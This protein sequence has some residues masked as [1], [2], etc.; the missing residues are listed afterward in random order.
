M[1]DTGHQHGERNVESVVTGLLVTQRV[2]GE[3]T[4]VFDVRTAAVAGVACGLT[5]FLLRR[6]FGRI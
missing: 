2:D 5:Y 6:L 3:V 4:A 1:D